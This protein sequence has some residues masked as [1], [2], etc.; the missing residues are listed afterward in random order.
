MTPVN[1]DKSCIYCGK[2]FNYRTKFGE[3]SNSYGICNSCEIRIAEGG[4]SARRALEWEAIR[5]E[6]NN[7]GRRI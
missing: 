6:V 5:N 2:T 1:I 7:H 3:H 4:E